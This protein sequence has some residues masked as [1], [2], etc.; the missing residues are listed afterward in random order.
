MFLGLTTRIS[1][2]VGLRWLISNKFPGDSV[3]L[4]NLSLKTAALNAMSQKDKEK[5]R[6]MEILL[7]LSVRVYFLLQFGSPL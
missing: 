5:G 3:A 4:G 1:D 2:S 7:A 6:K